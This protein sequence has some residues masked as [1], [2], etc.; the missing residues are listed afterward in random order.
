MSKILIADDNKQIADVLAKFVAKEGMEPVIAS[1]G[2]MALQLFVKHAPNIVMV[3]LDV[4]MPKM[5]GFEVCKTIRRDSMVPIIMITA[6]DEDYDRI[7]GLDMGADDYV[8]KPFSPTEVMAR[9]RAVLRRIKSPAQ[10][11][12]QILTISNLFIDI[13]R[14]EVRIGTE[15]VSLTK[16]EVELL[17][18]L[19]NTHI[20]MFT[21]DDLLDK[22]WGADYEGTDRVVDTHIKRL[23]AKLNNYKHP[24]W[25]IKTVWGRG[26]KFEV[27]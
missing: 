13:D 19:A 23:R 18:T 7:M 6:R 16:K 1:D 9:I 5:D 24:E 21:R 20:K 22:V 8:V 14:Y 4:M 26:Y 2:E 10:P 12:G 3:L 27:L 25:D 11:G 17:Y 15:S